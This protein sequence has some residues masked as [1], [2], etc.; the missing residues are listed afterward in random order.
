M[1]PSSIN[2]PIANLPSHPFHSIRKTE[3]LP[4]NYPRVTRILSSPTPSLLLDRNCRLNCLSDP[5]TAV[6]PP[7]NLVSTMD[8][9]QNLEIGSVADDKYSK[10]LEIAVK[11]VHMACLLCERHSK[12]DNFLV[13][14]ADWSVQAIVSW[15]LS[16]AFGSHSVAIL[17]EEDKQEISKAEA[18][19]ILESVAKAVNESLAY[20]PRF[21]L[22][23]PAE[24]LCTKEIME[25]I[26][27]CKL[28][29]ADA[30][31]FWA[32]GTVDST[33]G[34]PRGDQYAVA[35]SLI[36]DGAPVLGVLGCPNYPLKK[37]W[38]SYHYG[39]QRILS[40]LT[41]AALSEPH[42]DKGC[43]MYA[44]RGDGNAWMQ[45]LLHGEKM[46]NWPNSSKQIKPSSIDS[47]VLATFC[48][49]VE[50]KA[51]SSHSFTAGL[52]SSLGHRNQQLRVYSSMK[53]AAIA[54]GDAEAFMKFARAGKKEKVWDHAAG[55]V[56]IQEAGGVV[57]DAGGDP[58]DFSNGA[59]IE[60]LDRGVIA[61][62]GPKLHE[63]IIRAVDESWCSSCL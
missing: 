29:G 54:R 10:E 22:T 34:S 33:L 55:V 7:K 42:R 36:E 31:R 46:F 18:T 19:G 58:L 47:P 14:I 52:N 21:G 51:K 12:D 39:Y 30:S 62:A 26:N 2:F 57:T 28:A 24:A 17:A 11:A 56:I 5:T 49:T 50:E 32:L 6:F 13:T 15:V 35:L 63:N 27:T 4:L 60:G 1:P 37:E 45:P 38:L 23:G 20:A 40:R 8:K 41:S 53:Y 44:R 43:V 9:T 48:E 59:C 16:E 61:C 25:T 3:N